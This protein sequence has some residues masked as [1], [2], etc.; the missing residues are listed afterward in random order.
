MTAKND[1]ET[2]VVPENYKEMYSSEKRAE[3]TVVPENYKEIMSFSAANSVFQMTVCKTAADWWSAIV[4]LGG[5]DVNWSVVVFCFLFLEDL[6]KGHF[7]VDFECK[8]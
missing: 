4:H 5:E 3:T 2:A 7:L 8:C 6:L 1:A